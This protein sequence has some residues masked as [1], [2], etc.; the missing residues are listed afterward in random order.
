MVEAFLSTCQEVG[1]VARGREIFRQHCAKCHRHGDVGENIGPNLSGMAVHP[2]SE[3]LVHILDPSRSVEGNFRLYSIVQTDGRLMSGMLAGESKTSLELIDT[4]GKK[5]ALQRDDIAEIQASTKSMMPEGFEKTV[6]RI[7]LVHLLEFLTYKG[8][9]LPLDLRKT[10]TIA[11]DRGMFNDE[12]NVGE[13]L[14]FADWRPVEFQHVPFVLID[15][16]DG[17]VPNVILLHSPRGSIPPRMPK[18]ARVL[19]NSTATAIHLLSGVGGWCFP[20]IAEPTVSLTVRLHY[21]DGTHEDHAFYNG[22]DFA[23]YI[24]RVDV[25]GSEFAFDLQGRQMR[26]LSFRPTAPMPSFRSWN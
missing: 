21:Q 15:P 26:Y 22:R 11:S 8:R 1:D 20:A 12:A 4:E 14:V 25:P 23:D 3:L 18:T 24:R 16:Q 13:Q 6:S 10:A 5:H 17:R 9:Y 2:K 7:E 19:V